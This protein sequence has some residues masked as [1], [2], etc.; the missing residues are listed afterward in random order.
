MGGIGEALKPQYTRKPG[1]GYRAPFFPR[2]VCFWFKL[3][4]DTHK[5]LEQNKKASMLLFTS[6]YKRFVC[7]KVGTE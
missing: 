7:S 5:M 6:I 1:F 2:K 4:K 3:Q